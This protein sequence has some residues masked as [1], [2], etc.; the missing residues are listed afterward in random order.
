MRTEPSGTEGGV[1]DPPFQHVF[2]AQL[3]L[4]GAVQVRTVHP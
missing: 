2:T 1:G 3:A 4:G